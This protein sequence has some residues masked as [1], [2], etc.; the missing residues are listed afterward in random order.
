MP[1]EAPGGVLTNRIQDVLSAY[2]SSGARIVEPSQSP[3]IQVPGVQ[4]GL[5]LSDLPVGARVMLLNFDFGSFTPADIQLPYRLQ[6]AMYAEV[7]GRGSGTDMITMV[8]L[9][10][11]WELYKRERGEFG[12]KSRALCVGDA[13]SPAILELPSGFRRTVMFQGDS[14]SPRTS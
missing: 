6:V 12:L 5:P 11:P 3:L 4:I 7:T 10:N 14:P 1:N 2:P 13:E 9:T 8:P